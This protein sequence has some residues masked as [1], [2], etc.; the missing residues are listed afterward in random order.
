MA[1]ERWTNFN[2]PSPK[3]RYP[4]DRPDAIKIFKALTLDNKPNEKVEFP[5][6]IIVRFYGNEKMNFFETEFLAP[7]MRP[8]HTTDEAAFSHKTTLDTNED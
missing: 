4:L 6:D 2:T 3:P 7:K 8:I 1:N 5:K